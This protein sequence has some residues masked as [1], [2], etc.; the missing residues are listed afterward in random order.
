MCHYEKITGKNAMEL[1]G[2]DNKSATDL[3]DLVFVL[4]YTKDNAATLESIE[5]MSSDEFSNLLEEFSK[6]TK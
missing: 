6:E 3:R 1:F 2:K 4:K 5:N